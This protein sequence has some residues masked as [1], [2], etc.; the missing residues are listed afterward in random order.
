MYE[1]IITIVANN[2]V[3]KTVRRVVNTTT[4]KAL[5]TLHGARNVTICL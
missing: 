1:V 3:V 5:R 2:K 4:L